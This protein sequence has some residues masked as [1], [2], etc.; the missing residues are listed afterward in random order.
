MLRLSCSHGKEINALI[1]DKE[2]EG[3]DAY[4]S[5]WDAAES[6]VALDCSVQTQSAEATVVRST[7]SPAVSA[8]LTP[9]KASEVTTDVVPTVRLLPALDN[10]LDLSR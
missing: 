7:L 8:V 9:A 5:G 4:A 6:T 3:R 1:S 10:P 2:R